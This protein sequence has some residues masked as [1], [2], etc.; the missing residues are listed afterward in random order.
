MTPYRT[1]AAGA[2]LAIV[3]LHF[4]SPAAAD[5][6]ADAVSLYERGRFAE[7]RPL[8][9]QIDAAGN[10]DGPLLYRL[11][12]CQRQAGDP[13]AAATQDRAR[14]ALENALSSATGLDIPFYLANTYDNLGRK[15]DARRIAAEATSGVEAEELPRPDNGTRMFQLGKLYADQ[16]LEEQAVE[17]YTKA[18]DA[19]TEEGRSRGPYVRWASRFLAE[20]GFRNEDFD[21]AQKYYGAL[22]ASGAGQAVDFDRQAVALVRVGQY[23]EAAKAWKQAE[24]LN[25]GQGDRARYCARL[26]GMASRLEM[27]GQ[28]PSGKGWDEFSKEELQALMT[29]QANQVKSIRTELAGIESLT[30]EDRERLG[31]ALDRIKPVFVAATLEY[32]TRGHSIREAAFF[33]GFAPLLFQNKQWRIPAEKGQKGKKKRNT[34]PAE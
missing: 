9:E 14:E 2:L 27:P 24:T 26:A 6:K 3:L 31:S 30:A 34:K 19:L 10:A 21:S 28:A 23:K 11:A 18:I 17:W 12:Y 32:A 20:R 4:S 33:G 16:D 22:T 1:F 25:P 7:A 15:D 29:D 13:R 5:P 8:L